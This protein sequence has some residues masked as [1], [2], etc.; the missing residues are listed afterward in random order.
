MKIND[1]QITQ[2]GLRTYDLAEMV[3]FVKSGGIFTQ[4]VLDD[5]NSCSGNN[6]IMLNRF[7][8]GRFFLHD[9][10]HRVAAIWLAG[11]DFI[12][13][14]ELGGF[15]DYVYARYGRPNFDR[16][17]YTPFDPRTQVRIPDFFD[18]KEEVR[19]MAVEDPAR[20]VSYIMG[21][22]DRYTV[23]RTEKHDHISG[24]LPT[25]ILTTTS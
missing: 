17:W 21:H 13:P 14:E 23:P 15:T 12:Y 6:L 7:E 19:R 20:A 5:Y 16:G 1:L 8:D 9:G 10:H 18:F 25:S 22:R 4:K 11:R 2:D 24:I 3:A